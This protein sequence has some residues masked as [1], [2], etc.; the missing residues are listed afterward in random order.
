MG[1]Y[2]YYSEWCDQ[3]DEIEENRFL[4][5]DD[6]DLLKI[7]DRMELKNKGRQKT[8][9]G[10]P[11]HY[12][13]ENGYL[14]VL[15]EGPHTRVCGE[16]GSKKSRTVCRGGVIS[17]IANGD[18][19]ICVD[20]KGEISTDK[21]IQQFAID[22]NV[23]IYVL[24]FRNFDKDG[25]NLFGYIA[26][27]MGRGEQQR[28]METVDA[29]VEMLVKSKK[30]VD[31]FWNDMG[32]VLIKS[33]M[34]MLLLTLVQNKKKLKKAYNIASLRTFICQDKDSIYGWIN[35]IVDDMPK[36]MIY[37]PFQD[38]L[39]ILEN[40]EK[41]Y[42]C[43]ISSANAMLRDFCTS[44]NLM[45]MLSVQTFDIK[46]F[47]ERQSG[48]YLVIPDEK[49]TYDALTG[50]LLDIMYQML[51][52]EYTE[53]YQNKRYASHGIKYICDEV[54]S[55]KINQMANKISASR[56]RQIDWTLIYQSERQMEDAY[57]NDF[58]TICGNCKHQIFL[59][60]SDHDILKNIANQTGTTRISP[61]GTE[62]PLVSE[63]DLR[64]MRKEREYKD[65]LVMSGNC[66]YC[67]QLPDYDYYDFLTGDRLYQYKNY[68]ADSEIIIYTPQKLHD[69]HRYGRVD[70]Y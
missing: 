58:A 21:K 47:Y 5:S 41:T 23:D 15:K 51:I 68:V 24:D 69:D 25:F 18:S 37:N 59:G 12:D 39:D 55:T 16:S 10:L 6:E 64:R 28:A 3:A 62:V 40:P 8:S 1:E 57:P 4:S 11:I 2:A 19:F 20:P 70:F 14:Y 65:A 46:K 45:K 67:A 49:N 63:N 54:A 7:C 13:K 35:E 22:H 34:N 17:A 30:T 31:D 36:D 27:M 38:Y 33:A 26:D 60:S 53:K 29:F 48:L 66:L 61:D 44:E 32:G 50:Y 52:E 56:S 43:I 9:G 42:A